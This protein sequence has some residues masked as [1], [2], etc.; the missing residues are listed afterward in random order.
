MVVLAAFA[1]ATWLYSRVPPAAERRLPADGTEPLGYYL[2]AASMLGTD[3]QG[4]VAYRIMADNLQELPDQQLLKLEGVRIE[5]VPAE[6]DHWLIS[7]AGGTAPKDNSELTLNGQV[8]L[9]SEPRSG[10]KPLL[11]A[12]ETLRF[13]P[14]S[15]SAESDTPVS[16]RVGDWHFE[17]GGFRTHLKGDVVQL[18]SKVHAKSVR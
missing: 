9:R 7:A 6:A 17:A 14:E 10:G 8:T 1:V 16:I 15:S 5:Y 11:I 18:E 2:R 12:S 13:F 4:R 3:D